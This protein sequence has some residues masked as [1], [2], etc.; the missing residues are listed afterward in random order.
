MSEPIDPT[1]NE[2]YLWH[3]TTPAAAEAI[4]TGDFR[5]DLAGSHAGTM[6]GRGI[7]FAEACSKSDEYTRETS[8]GLRP[9]LLCRV[10]CGR[11]LYN[12]EHH[13]TVSKLVSSCTSGEYDCVLGDREKIRNTYREFIVFDNDQ[14]YPEFIVWYRR[15]R[16]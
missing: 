14:A 12:D 2:F 7:Y 15:K 16:Q 10:L 13:P 4:T 11:V 1:K 9:L 5:I 8:D 3:G 6:Y